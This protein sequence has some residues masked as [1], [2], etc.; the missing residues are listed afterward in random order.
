M[1]LVEM[2]TDMLAQS[3]LLPLW[4]AVAPWLALDLRQL[5]FVIATPFF[6][7]VALWEYRRIRHDDTLMNA[8]EAMRN[9]MLGAGYQVTEL[10]FAGLIAASTRLA[11]RLLVS[12]EANSV[13]ARQN[14]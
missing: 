10:V 5:I 4:Q 7:G 6:V 13:M 8:P 12:T 2:M 3:G 11:L 1:N 9:F 14:R